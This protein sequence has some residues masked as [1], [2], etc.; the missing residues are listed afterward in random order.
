MSRSP[1]KLIP[2]DFTAVPSLERS[3]EVQVAV[4]AELDEAG[5]DAIGVL[6]TTDGACPTGS[7]STVRRS[8]GRASR[9]SP[10]RPSCCP[11]ARVRCSWWSEPAPQAS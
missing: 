8:S 10:V 7:T 5:L 6:V 11:T 1:N 4:V 2:E 9:A 3:R